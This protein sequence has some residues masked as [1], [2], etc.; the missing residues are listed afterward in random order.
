MIEGKWDTCEL[1]ESFN[2]PN[3]HDIL[4]IK[5]ETNEEDRWGWFINGKSKYFSTKAAYDLLLSMR[6]V[7][8]NQSK[9][10]L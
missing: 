5:V 4:S 6:Q 7:E 8:P 2:H 9:V 1:G 3:I 10:D